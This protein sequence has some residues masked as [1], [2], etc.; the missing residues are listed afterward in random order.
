ML[1][2][3]H[4]HLNDPSLDSSL[5]DVME[6]AQ[7]VGVTRYIVPAYDH[8]SL[9]RTAV[10]SS[11]HPGVIFPAYG[12]HPW[13]L[14]EPINYGELLSFMKQPGR[15]AVG[16][17][18]L[19]FSPGCPA[20]DIQI[21]AFEQQLDFALWLDLPVIIHCRK[22]HEVVLEIFTGYKKKL[23]GVMHSFSGSREIMERFIDLGFHISFSGSVTR[24]TARKYHR[25]VVA[26]PIDRLLLETDAPSIA[27]ETTIASEVEPRHTAEVARKVSELRGIPFEEV[28]RH[29]TGNAEKLFNLPRSEE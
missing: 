29:T 8:D 11:R 25:N 18:G 14:N 21:D 3:T 2:D 10:L 7:A 5:S 4:C 19:D 15:I 24:R 20:R 28:C 23:R 26:V 9:E 12:V 13:Y 22:A 6:R 16:E 27:T 17:I 1:I